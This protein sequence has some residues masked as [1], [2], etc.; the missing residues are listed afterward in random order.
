MS[1]YSTAYGEFLA[2]TIHQGTRAGNCRQK[3][4]SATVNS[5]RTILVLEDDALKALHLMTILQS[6]GAEVFAAADAKEG[7]TIAQRTASV[8][9]HLSPRP[10]ASACRW[11][12]RIGRELSCHSMKDLGSL[13]PLLDANWPGRACRGGCVSGQKRC[14]PL[15]SIRG[16]SASRIAHGSLQCGSMRPGAEAVISVN[17]LRPT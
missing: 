15:Q 5:G 16:S 12:A 6:E 4:R 10:G 7:Y 13:P 2:T 14:V 9:C 11:R 1:N 8:H 17:S 3:W